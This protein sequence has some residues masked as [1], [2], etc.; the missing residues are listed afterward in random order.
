MKLA[1]VWTTFNS[2]AGDQKRTLA[3]AVDGFLGSVDT[4]IADALGD[5]VLLIVRSFREPPVASTKK[6]LDELLTPDTE[7]PTPVGS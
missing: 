3:K 5:K 6:T 1:E 4:S 2:L 7:T